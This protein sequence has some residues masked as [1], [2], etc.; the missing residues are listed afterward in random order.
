[1]SNP[2]AD[3]KGTFFALINDEGQYCLW[4]AFLDVPA[5]WTLAHPKAGREACLH[6]INTPWTNMRPKSLID[7]TEVP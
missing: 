1:M 6:F 7:S 2:F 5:G 4:P 3:N